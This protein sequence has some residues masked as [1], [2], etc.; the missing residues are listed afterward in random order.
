MVEDAQIRAEDRGEKATIRA[1]GRG[2]ESKKRGAIFENELPMATSEREKAD[3]LFKK[4]KETDEYRNAMP[5]SES[6]RS[7]LGLEHSNRLGEI[8][9]QGIIQKQI[10]EIGAEGREKK[11]KKLGAAE[12]KELGER[13]AQ[14]L[15]VNLRQDGLP[16]EFNPETKTMQSTRPLTKDEQGKATGIA[17]SMNFEIAFGDKEKVDNPGLLTGDSEVKSFSGVAWG[18]PKLADDG[19]T[20]ITTLSGGA[21]KQPTKQS[22]E[23]SLRS[24]MGSI[25]DTKPKTQTPTTNEPEKKGVVDKAMGGDKPLSI[26][27][28][29]KGPQG[30]SEIFFIQDFAQSVKKDPSNWQAIASS[31]ARRDDIVQN[32]WVKAM[33]SVYGVPVKDLMTAIEAFK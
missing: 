18:G 10:A 2:E 32:R 31:V 27:P 26:N 13:E 7:R 16:F 25:G 12:I 4:Q 19:K 30:D 9:A 11:D 14:R 22:A 17:K 8:G 28:D 6:D 15:F 3:L 33:N 24:L 21:G 1:E 29:L 23:E 5:L 20:G